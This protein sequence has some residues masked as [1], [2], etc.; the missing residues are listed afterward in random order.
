MSSDG[1]HET[2]RS[3]GTASYSSGGGEDEELRSAVQHELVRQQQ[4]EQH[5]HSFEDTQQSPE[6][7]E[8]EEDETMEIHGLVAGQRHQNMSIGGSLSDDG[9]DDHLS[10]RGHRHHWL[11][12]NTSTDE[13]EYDYIDEDHY[14]RSCWRTTVYSPKLLMLIAAFLV[15]SLLAIFVPS[16]PEET[17]DNPVVRKYK[18]APQYV[19]PDSNKLS[20]QI[21]PGHVLPMYQANSTF[22]L[23]LADNFTTYT[24][25]FRDRPF[26]D[27]GN[28]T[29][30]QVKESLV[31]WKTSRFLPNLKT[32]DSVFESGC[33]IGLSLFLTLEILQENNK[34]LR[35]LHLYGS[36]FG[37]EAA[38]AAN[39]LLDH[40]LGAESVGGGKRGVVC[41]ADSTQLDFIPN[42]TFDLV[43]AGH[44]SPDPNPYGFPANVSDNAALMLERR[45]E[46]C[47]TLA[48]GDWKSQ[49]LQEAAQEKQ[50]DWYGRWIAEMVRIAKPGAPVIVEQVSDPYCDAQQFDEW[51][52]GVPYSFWPDAIGQFQ[53]D[54]DP[55]S[56]EFEMDTLFQK[57]RYHVFMRKN[58][59]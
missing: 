34:N 45:R 36:D 24:E 26:R 4:E 3:V 55:T 31:H 51:G 37:I 46:I 56:I 53:W 30:D 23:D 52:G 16:A 21:T 29:Y 10:Y 27:W 35:D 18:G 32:G 13:Y 25:T 50:N 20:S 57:H 39:L 28:K 40:L 6:E 38:G 44:I 43:F 33:G 19:C 12:Q 54:V 14:Y 1:D 17:E 11:G 58:R 41:A 7:E 48:A 5:H 59:H 15:V 42:D 9:T 49:A 2:N 22:L 8:D 47:A